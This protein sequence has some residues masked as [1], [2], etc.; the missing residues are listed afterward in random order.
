MKQRWGEALLN[1]PAYS[2]NL[3]L[4]CEDFSLAWPPVWSCC[5]AEGQVACWPSKRM[6]PV[7]RADSSI[8]E[9]EQC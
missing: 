4:E 3:T 5:W 9:K 2:P 7:R 6:D 8:E 1:D